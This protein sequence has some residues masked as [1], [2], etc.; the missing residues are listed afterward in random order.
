MTNQ[1]KMNK[2]I[3]LFD[4]IQLGVCFLFMVLSFIIVWQFKQ[5]LLSKDAATLWL[6]V[7]LCPC[8]FFLGVFALFTGR[9]WTKGTLI[10]REHMPILF[11]VNVIVY[12]LFSLISL[13]WA[14]SLYQ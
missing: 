13:F 4:R 7:L 2:K 5:S 10:D 12:F 14:I 8:F 3:K 11:A 6:L 9:S 1:T